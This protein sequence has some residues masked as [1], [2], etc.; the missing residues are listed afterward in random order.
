ML[1]GRRRSRREAPSAAAASAWTAGDLLLPGPERSSRAR[2]WRSLPRCSSPRMPSPCVRPRTP[3]LAP[4][5]AAFEGQRV[6]AGGHV[7]GEAD[8]GPASAHAW[9]TSRHVLARLL[10]PARPARWGSSRVSTVTWASSVRRAAARRSSAGSAFSVADASTPWQVAIS[11]VET[12][13]LDD[14]P[15]RLRGCRARARRSRPAR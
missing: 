7:E 3:G 12:E 15:K 2:S 13:G 1:G 8:G 5:H 14:A 10:P 9:R 11:F 4:A 6:A